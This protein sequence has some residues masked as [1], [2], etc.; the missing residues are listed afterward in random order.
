MVGILIG[1]LSGWNSINKRAEQRLRRTQ[2]RRAI[3]EKGKGKRWGLLIPSEKFRRMVLRFGIYKE[4]A[5]LLAGAQG[6]VQIL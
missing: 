4:T 2:R 3:Q 1:V 5:F 6:R